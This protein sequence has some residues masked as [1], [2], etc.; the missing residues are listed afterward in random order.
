MWTISYYQYG[1]LVYPVSVYVLIQKRHA[2]ALTQW[3]TSVRGVLSVFL[4]TLVWTAAYIVGVQVVEFVSAS[5]L[6]IALFWTIAGTNAM[7]TAAFPLL[8]F[9]VAVPMGEFL[10]RPLMQITANISSA[11]LALS[12]FPV[13]R[14]GQFFHLPGGSFEVADVCSG[15]KYLLAGAL[16]AL[17]FSYVTYASN[18]K[19]LF[20]VIFVS[21]TVVIANGVRAF[22]VMSVES[23]T[24]MKVFG[25][26]DHVIFGMVMFAAAFV[27]LIWIGYRYADPVTED[28][29]PIAIRREELHGTVSTG[30][31]VLGLALVLAGPAFAKAIR[32]QPGVSIADLPF[33]ELHSCIQPNQAIV[34][35]FPTF[36][37]A[38]YEK[39]ARYACGDFRTSL[40]VASYSEQEQG[41]ELVSWA[42]RVWPR[43][44]SRYVEQTRVSLQ[45]A[46]GHVD[47]QQIAVSH[48]RGSRLIWFWYQVGPSVSGNETHVKFLEALQLLTFDPVESSVVVIAVAGDS[49][50]EMDTLRNELERHTNQIMRWNRE[51][52]ALGAAR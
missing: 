7:R 28:D 49:Q 12:G 4:L 13:M 8:L 43:D 48:P 25:G 6:I 37:G 33:P 31:V 22:I 34:E 19:R 16:L 21:V 24:D 30:V 27:V 9:V 52:V 47:V 11:L 45:L 38:D 35:E 46:D 17:V 5:L 2:L 15:F 14:D 10:V 44:W 41:K 42:N 18:V 40:Y 26:Y 20:F 23:A 3:S 32:D 51:R 50:S 36:L 39:R 1:W 29:P